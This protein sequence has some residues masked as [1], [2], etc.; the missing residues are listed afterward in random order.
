MSKGFDIVVYN[1]EEVLNINLDS[2]AWSRIYKFFNIIGIEDYDAANIIHAA[3]QGSKQATVCHN[4]TAGFVY[5]L[6]EEID[7]PGLPFVVEFVPSQRTT[8]A[9]RPM[10]AGDWAA[11]K[12]LM[13][14]IEQQ[15]KLR[16]RAQAETKMVR[17]RLQHLD[18][19][20]RRAQRALLVNTE[21]VKPLDP[22][23]PNTFVIRPTRLVETTVLGQLTD[24][25]VR[26]VVEI[27]SE[28]SM[29]K[30]NEAAEKK[31]SHFRILPRLQQPTLDF[32]KQ[33]R[34]AARP[35]LRGS[36]RGAD[37]V[38]GSLKH[39][40]NAV[41]AMDNAIIETMNSKKAMKNTPLRYRKSRVQ[42]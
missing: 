9:Q 38:I 3:A 34:R 1:T 24:D 27:P 25:V 37:R 29:K 7:I 12:T 28:H 4:V 18:R 16:E 22:D 19:S 40:I 20:L 15:R 11:Y 5:D 2:N 42:W 21:D 31:D 32:D 17:D 33:L 39:Y 30:I 23:D 13:R 8:P 6:K 41:T 26:I 10:A 35:S 14:E 36:R